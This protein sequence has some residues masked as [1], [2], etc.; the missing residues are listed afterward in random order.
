MKNS[1]PVNAPYSLLARYYDCL[2]GEAAAMNRHARE[3]ILRTILP[4]V[5]RVCD[6]ACGSGETALDLARSGL[7]V[8]AVDL[9][10]VFCRAVR[11][12][13]RRAGLRI[14]VHCADM[15]DFVLP[16]PVDLVLAEFAALN[17]LADRSDLPRVFKAVS[18][19]LASGGSF[20]FD[21]NTPLALRTQYDQ[22]YWFE[23]PAFKLAQR[24]SLEADGRRARLDFEWFVPARRSWRHV[25]ETLWN[26]CW[27][28]AEIR[29]ALRAAGFSQ[30][31]RF[32][33]VDVR[34][35]TPGARRGTD[36]Y[37]LAHR[38]AS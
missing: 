13:A 8:H 23:G 4:N 1:R 6:L 16:D 34:P 3:R 5:R 11:A 33:G 30:V 14:A 38:G 27:T 18:R 28:D 26:V 31:R 22:T 29:R 9:S 25:R 7:E 2:V 32:D 35:R 21:V 12:K 20:L 19:A 24:G 36:A 15:R 17:N 37:Y 10:A